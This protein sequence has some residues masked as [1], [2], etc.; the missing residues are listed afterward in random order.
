MD[1]VIDE[2]LIFTDRTFT[3]DVEVLEFLANELVEKGY[4]K[5]SY[6]EA[7]LK[8][9][10][11]FPTGL[12]F[13]NYGV[14][15]PHSD[16]IHVNKSTLCIVVPSKPMTFRNMDGSGTVEVKLICNIVLKD[17]QNQTAMLS[18]LMGLFSDEDAVKEM[19]TGEISSVKKYL[20]QLVTS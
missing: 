7:L 9:E 17:K 12:N 2:E 19:I 14:A 8:R 10:Q 20:N 13:G 5:D 16:A 15:I 18:S 6:K 4:V 3:S 11:E 1:F